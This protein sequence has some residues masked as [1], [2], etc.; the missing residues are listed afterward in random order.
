MYIR[1]DGGIEGNLIADRISYPSYM[2]RNFKN[3]SWGKYPD[4][5]F[6]ATLNIFP[7]VDNPPEFDSATQR[8]TTLT[9]TY[10]SELGSWVGNYL[11]ENIPQEELDAQEASRREGILANIRSQ[12]D[13]LLRDSDWVMT[14]DAPIL[15]KNQWVVYRQLLRDIT[16]QNPNPDL[17]VFPQ[18]PAVVPS[19]SKI[20]TNYS[21]VFDPL[22]SPSS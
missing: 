21:G 18:K 9:S 19:G 8:R 2:K 17:I 15:N 4:N 1:T 3:V 12:R 10:N 16:S 20:N 13:Q 7:L 11:V 6:L 14:A 22:G 5:G